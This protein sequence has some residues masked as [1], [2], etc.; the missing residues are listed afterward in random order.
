MIIT[1]SDFTGEYQVPQT[2]YSDLDLYINKYTKLYLEQML[3]VELYKEFDADLDNGIPQTERFE[4]I[5]NSLSYDK[6]NC[7]YQSEGIKQMLVE[8]VYYHFTVES[9]LYN[10]STGTMSTDSELSKPKPY[11]NNIIS[12]Y[13]K[14]VSNSRVIQYY[15]LDNKDDYEKENIQEIGYID[16]I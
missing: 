14:A 8:F 6:D 1:T 4:V 2:R 13:N 10:T 9:Q 12:A 3:G 16:G 15:I 7:V 5:F 11:A